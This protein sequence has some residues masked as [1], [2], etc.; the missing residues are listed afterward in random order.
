MASDCGHP[1]LFFLI[2][3]EFLE[4]GSWNI[5]D[6]P[7]DW[8]SVPLLIGWLAFALAVWI[9]LIGVFRWPLL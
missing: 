1:V 6:G 3:M 5:Y 2:A 4:Y 7:C 8:R 9:L